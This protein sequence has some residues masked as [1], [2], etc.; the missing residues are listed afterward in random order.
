ME[1]CLCGHL[2]SLTKNI[3]PSLT[4]QQVISFVGQIALGLG[5]LHD[6]GILHRDIKLA[7]ALVDH[8]GR[9]KV[10]DLGSAVFLE[11]SEWDEMALE[12]TPT[13]FSPEQCCGRSYGPASDIFQLGVLL[14]QLCTGREPFLCTDYVGLRAVHKYRQELWIREA[15]CDLHDTPEGIEDEKDPDC[16]GVMHGITWQVK[17]DDDS[18]SKH[19]RNLI[20]CMLH[21]SE[22]DRLTLTEFWKHRAVTELAGDDF[23]KRLLQGDLQTW[24]DKPTWKVIHGMVDANVR[25]LKRTTTAIPSDLRRR[26]IGGLDEL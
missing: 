11:E 8:T 12:Q 21:P 3:R 20:E 10:G 9:V 13:Y 25:K 4:L 14:Y 15:R 17:F 7:N 23:Q 22:D 5:W 18:V 26:L 19:L 1:A 16:K 6:N 24:C 2:G